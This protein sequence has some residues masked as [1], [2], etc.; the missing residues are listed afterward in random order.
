MDYN[1]SS[2][3]K[4]VA[5]DLDG[6]IWSPDMYQ[7]WGGGAPFRQASNKVDLLD[8]SGSKVRLLGISGQILHD[9]HVH[10]KFIENDT[11]IAWVSCTDEPEWAN[12]CLQKFST[13]GNK[14][15]ASIVHSVQ[16]YKADKRQHFQNLKKE[17]PHIDYSEM[18]FFD[19]ERSNIVSVSRLGVKCIYAPDGMTLDVGEK[20]LSLFD[21]N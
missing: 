11:K 21:T 1:N 2:V 5:F 20:G 6:T 10:P 8:R 18:L 4:L 16:I 7:L 13:N 15:L 9:L 19:N 12:E 17:F 3:P 14:P